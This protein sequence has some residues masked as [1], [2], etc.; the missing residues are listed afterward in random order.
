MRDDI[1]QGTTTALPQL[2]TP[3]D[4]MLAE[5]RVHVQAHLLCAWCSMQAA[6]RQ[7]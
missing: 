4:C 2:R 1:E 7:G 5:R 3:G 6:M